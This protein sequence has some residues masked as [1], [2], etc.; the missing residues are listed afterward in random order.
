MTLKA[1]SNS[2]SGHKNI[3]YDETAHSYAV[4]IYRK[5]NL[6]VTYLDTLDEAIFVRDKV[7]DFYKKNGFLPKKSDLT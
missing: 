4:R 2:K 3:H 1:Q 7:Y 5:H 6:F